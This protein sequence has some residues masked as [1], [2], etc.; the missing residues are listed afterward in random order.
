MWN[1]VTTRGD[2]VKDKQRIESIVVENNFVLPK[3]NNGT[4]ISSA[5]QT[6]MIHIVALIL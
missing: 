6:C 4:M 5:Y 1:L 3:S 2:V